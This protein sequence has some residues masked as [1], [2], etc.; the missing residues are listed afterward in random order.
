MWNKIE[1]SQ[2]NLLS[3]SAQTLLCLGPMKSNWIYVNQGPTGPGIPYFS[4]PS[5]L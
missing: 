3:T 1:V 4:F 5:H 2:S